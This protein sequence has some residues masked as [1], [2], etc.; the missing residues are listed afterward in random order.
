MYSKNLVNYG[1]VSRGECSNL[2]DSLLYLDDTKL[3]V[4]V[5]YF[6]LH[7]HLPHLLHTNVSILF[8]NNLKMYVILFY[9]TGRRSNSEEE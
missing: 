6:S 8:W 2:L 5:C 4:V 3:A 7:L 9:K 1:Y